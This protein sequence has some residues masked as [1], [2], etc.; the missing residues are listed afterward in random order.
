MKKILALLLLSALILTGCIANKQNEK[1]TNEPFE[2]VQ[3]VDIEISDYIEEDNSE[4]VENTQPPVV[5]EAPQNLQ[6]T[7][8]TPQ[9]ETTAQPENTQTSTPVT[10][11][12]EDN[13]NPQSTESDESILQGKIICIDAGHGIFTEK[14]NDKIGPNSNVEKA[15]FKVGTKGK[16]YIEDEITLAVA[17]K[18]KALLENSGVTVLM[19]RTDENSTMTNAERAVWA[20]ENNAELVIKLH[21]DGTKEGGSGMTM[22]VPGSAYIEDSSVI[23]NSKTLA[24]LILKNAKNLTGARNRGVYT[25]NQ[26][27]GLNWSKVPVVLFE[28][29][30]M[31]NSNDEKKLADSEYQQKLAEGI[32]NGIIEYYK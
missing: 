15:G 25:T 18:V 5:T 21:A 9:P 28:M 20:N 13:T 6:E 14:R 17:N 12:T 27:A 23:K 2:E 19:T 29:G 11:E 30:F 32:Y 4:V 7:Q 8:T 10:N 31:T 24:K 3:K 1:P 22:L 26:M 16:T